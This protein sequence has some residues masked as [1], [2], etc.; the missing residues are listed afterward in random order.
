MNAHIAIWQ[1]TMLRAHRTLLWACAT[2]FL[3]MLAGNTFAQDEDT[4]ADDDPFSD[5]ACRLCPEAAGWWGNALFGLGWV[6]DDSLR[7]GSY[8]GLEQE[9]AYAALDGEVHYRDEQGRFLDLF[10]RDLGLDS[11]EFD[12]RG[13]RQGTYELRLGWHEIPYWR[14]YG[15]Q[16]PFGGQGTGTLK[17]P[18]DFVRAPVTSGMTN[19]QASLHPAPLKVQRDILDLGG[20]FRFSSAW[21]V[22]VNAQQQR[23]QGTRPLGGDGI[24][25]NN[26]TQLT[27]PVDFTTDQLEVGINWGNRRARLR[28]GFMGSWF[29]N[30]RQSLTWDNPFSSPSVVDQLRLALAPSNDY[31]QFSLTGSYS[32]TPRVHVSGHA[33]MG[34][35]SQNEPFLPYSINPDFSSVPLPRASLDGKV[36]TSVYNLGGKLSA[37]LN[38]RVS[39][40]A[41]A[42]YDER[43]NRTPVDVYTPV[44]TDIIITGER[45]NR[46]YSFERTQY[47]ADLRFRAHRT[48]RLSG[49]A[50]R[51][52]I[53][54]TLQ[55]VEE[56]EDTTW[57]GEI[58]FTPAARSQIRLKYEDISR[59]I[60]EYRNP[61][62]GGIPDNPMFRKYNQADRD[63]QRVLL[64]LFFT[65]VDGLGLNAS[66]YRAK[67]EYEESA[68][69]LQDSNV[70]GFTASFDYARGEA[71]TLY[72]FF[73][74]EDIESDMLG[75][76]G[77]QAWRADTRDRI[78]TAGVGFSAGISDQ[79]RLGLDVSW[80]ETK[81]EIAVQTVL[82]EDPFP[83]LRTELLNARMYVSHQLNEH[84]GFRLFAEFEDYSSEDWA[85]DGLGV[86][87]LDPV[88]TF[89]LLTPDYDVWNLSAQATYRF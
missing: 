6:S 74:R 68:L 87:G 20:S 75:R 17:L 89:G 27:A 38:S 52:E 37:R 58:G 23:K 73:T 47:S 50:R 45:M 28:L 86:D 8:R 11:R 19:L 70:S 62:L 66:A 77:I 65:P 82:K 30:G 21:S 25:L 48:L 44:T 57:W 55:A 29:D 12:V 76:N 63:R 88:L 32:F 42:K 60:S 4:T 39:F 22:D 35:M 85:I 81:G 14:G 54:R 78:A 36:D 26:A 79:T 33:A 16:T 43:D 49:G 53:D 2:L 69:G 7:F 59:D 40:T 10:T 83:K 5:W 46:P 67:D 15:A 80:A 56:S 13:G 72:G 71:F 24:Y 61:D 34:E 84:W 41:R 31:H 51:Y 64:Q 18:A 1:M 3:A 9:G